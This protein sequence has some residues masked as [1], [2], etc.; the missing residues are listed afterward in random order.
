MKPESLMMSYGYRPELSEGAL[1][2][3]IFQTS[4]FVFPSAEAGK[5]FFEVAYGQREQAPGEELGLIYSRLNNP[6][7]EI[8]EN[9]LALW[10]N[11][12]ACA[13]FESG[14]A[15]ISTGMLEFLPPGDLLLSSHPLYAGPHPFIHS[16]L[17][18]M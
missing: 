14:M 3:P 16:V 7:L 15:A 6:D 12:D 18:K 13:V 1:K 10:D 2:C 9:R 4:T 17:P 11:A 5:A 8:L